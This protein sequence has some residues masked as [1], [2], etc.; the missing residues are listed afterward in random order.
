[1]APARYT[2][3]LATLVASAPSGDSWLHEIKYDGYR[4]G[5]HIRGTRVT[6]TS[7][8]NKD[9]T[10]VFPEIVD[11]ARALGV[12]DALLDG[13][14]AI[15]L[16]DGR[17][18]FQALQN[19]IAVQGE[20]HS[21][22]YFVFDLVRLDGQS[23]ER[24]PLEERKARLQRLIGRSPARGS[25]I[26]YSEHVVGG[27][28]TFFST[29]C[30]H[31]LEGIISKQRSSPYR[32]GRH[33]DWV[34]TKCTRRQEFVIGGFTEPEGARVGIGALLIGYYDKQPGTTGARLV[35]SGKVGTGFTQKVSTEL[36]RMLDAREQRICPFSPAPPGWLGRHAHW[37]QPDLVCEVAFTEWTSDARIRHPSFQGLRQDKNP[38]DVRRE[39]PRQ[40][41][42]LAQS[43][44]DRK[45]QP[46]PEPTNIAAGV[47]ITHPDRVLYPDPPLN[48]LDIARYYERIADWIV[49][50]VA[51]RPLTLVRCPEG[52]AGDC[53]F[54]KHSK[55]WAPEPL[56]RVNIQEK[57]K[58]GEYLIADDIAGIVGLVQMGVLEI[59]TW[60]AVFP[61]IE[62]PNRIVMDIDPGEDV[63]W[64]QVVRA[65][66]TVKAMLAALDLES[67]VKTTGGRGL[68]VVVPLIPHASW[69][70]CLTFARNLAEALQRA[71]PDLFTTAFAR[72]GRRRKILLDY[73]RNN[74]T[75]TSIAGYST[76][77][78]AG[79]TV[80]VPISW[81]QLRPS[82]TPETFTVATV[83]ARVARSKQDPW[84]D[85]WISRQKLTVQRLRAAATVEP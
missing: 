42:S 21:L 4:I 62:R 71:D 31:G 70:D 18:S 75:N 54:M 49:P 9:W 1:M 39:L 27:G 61:D 67:F 74:R 10:A 13:E 46:N 55:V 22:V 3:Q 36:R 69:S 53:V 34:K 5:C 11:A 17:T 51:G 32:S 2:P 80:S 19:A 41:E 14:V 63:Q 78:R 8:N 28:Q 30:Q 81:E 85:Y 35:F 26:R 12:G 43:G 24:L 60:N 48:K 52:I 50:H 33:G 77:A 73:L 64:P 72:V 6:L 57:K 40:V 47:R 7:R 84:K 20:R 38:I 66:R 16:P 65:A 44:A 79:A 59:H 76:R 58:L 37:V 15:V 25:R 29:A 82:L 83:S 23:I 56:R 68:H 45:R